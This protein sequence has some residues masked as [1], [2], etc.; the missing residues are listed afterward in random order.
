MATVTLQG[1]P[2]AEPIR[3]IG[4]VAVAAMAAFVKGF[5]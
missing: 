3:T 5:G 4:I 1:G 2:Q